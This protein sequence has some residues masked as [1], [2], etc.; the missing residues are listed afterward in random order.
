MNKYIYIYT[1]D[2]SVDSKAT[3]LTT[4]IRSTATTVSPTNEPIIPE[5]QSGPSKVV[6]LAWYMILAWYIWH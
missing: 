3:A 2:R 1:Y 5:K 4:T 6:I